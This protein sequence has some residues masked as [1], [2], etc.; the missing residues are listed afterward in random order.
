MYEENIFSCG[1]RGNKNRDK[2]TFAI[3]NCTSENANIDDPFTRDTTYI[4]IHVNISNKG[5]TSFFIHNYNSNL[6]QYNY[7]YYHYTC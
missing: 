4:Y 6:C 7:F 1:K 2:N 3:K 5:N